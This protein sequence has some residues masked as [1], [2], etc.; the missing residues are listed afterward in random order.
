VTDTVATDEDAWAQANPGLGI[1]IST[2]HVANEQ[3]SMDPRTFAVERLGVGDW[4]DASGA[5]TVIDLDLW[6]S[7]ADA[8]SEISSG[9]CLAFDVTPD[10]A[11]SSIAAAGRR[12]DGL[13]HIEIVEARAG[14]GWVAGRV[15]QLVERHQPAAV[16]CD[17]AGPAGSL[18]PALEAAEIDVEVVAAAG[19]AKACGAFFDSV[20]ERQLRHLGSDEIRAALK[21]AARR[22]LGDSWAWSRKSS[23]VDISP[24]VASTLALWGAVA[25]PEESF[26]GM[27]V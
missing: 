12:D 2:E 18:L 4:P 25:Q 22:P 20:E 27:V 14:T 9:L 24:L 6:D 5:A 8:E 16:M 26:V 23:A 10:R 7:L 11:A 21:G 15:A 1:R 19:H 13:W 17:S 3:R